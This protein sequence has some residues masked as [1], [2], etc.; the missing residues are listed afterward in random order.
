MK[1][2]TVSL[3]DMQSAL[4]TVN[5]KYNDNVC[6]NRLDQSGR[7]IN[8]TLR[9]KSS[10]LPGH[11]VSHGGRHIPSACWH[12][13]RDFMKAIFDLSPTAVIRSCHAVYEGKEGFEQNYPKT[14]GIN[15]GSVMSPLHF[16]E[17]CECD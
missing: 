13:H 15:I 17:A 2:N 6:F 7:N 14:G 9:V 16:C 11:R 10:K 1:I 5:A 8:F 4:V 12:V 3:Q